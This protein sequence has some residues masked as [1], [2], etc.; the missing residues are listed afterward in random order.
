MANRKPFIPAKGTIAARMLEVLKDQPLTTTDWCKL[1][2]GLKRKHVATYAARLEKRGL[3]VR[4]KIPQT[5]TKGG[6][7]EFLYEHARTQAC[8]G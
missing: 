5:N 6:R 2:R 4:K 8:P 3:L 7:C 1:L